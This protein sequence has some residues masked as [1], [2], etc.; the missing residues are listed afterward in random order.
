LDFNMADF[1]I[2]HFILFSII[3]FFLGFLSSKYIKSFEHKDEKI[4]SFFAKENR[5][6]KQ[7]NNKKN[8]T[9]DID[10]SVHV[11]N[12]KTENLEK[13]YDTMGNKTSTSE[14]ISSSIAKLQNMKK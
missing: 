1:I 6:I 9:I 7:D 3:F 14:N 8:A 2:H 12:I 11:V 4:E 5:K 10:D 13:K